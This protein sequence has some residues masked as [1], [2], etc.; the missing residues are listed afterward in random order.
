[1]FYS[2][3]RKWLRP[4][5]RYLIGRYQ[6]AAEHPTG[7]KIVHKT[8]SRQHLEVAVGLVRGEDSSQGQT[9][10]QI[11]IRCLK[12]KFGTTVNG[13]A[14]PEGDHD[15]VG[16]EHEIALGKA[17]YHLKIVWQPVALSFSFGSKEFK[18]GKDPLKEVRKRLDNTDIV[19]ALEYLK[20]QTTHVVAGKRN[21]AKGLQALVNGRYMVH[22]TFVDALVYCT[23]PEN[24]D[25]PESFCPLE[26]DFDQQ[27][28]DAL[29]YLPPRSKEPNERPSEDFAPNIHRA[30][31]FEGYTFV[32][33]D[34]VQFD[35]L[36]APISDGG[37]KTLHFAVEP[38]VTEA[39]DLLRYVKSA[40]GEKGLGE[41]EDGSEG[42]GVVIVKLIA[43]KQ[44]QWAEQFVKTVS[45][46]T[47][48]RMIEQNEFLEAILS[49]N[50]GIL[51]RPLSVED[52]PGSRDAPQS[53]TQPSP[54]EETQT[55]IKMDS[56]PANLRERRARRAAAKKF[57]GF[58]DEVEDAPVSIP[59]ASG[60]DMQSQAP[61]SGPLAP[62]K[63]GFHDDMDDEDTTKP[64]TDETQLSPAG[65]SKKRPAPEEE[66]DDMIDAILPAAAAL[67]RRRIEERE[68]GNERD[69]SPVSALST[70]PTSKAKRP[71]KEIDIKDVVRKRREAEEEA[72]RRDEESLQDIMQ[73]M[74]VEQMKSL[75]VVEEME[76]PSRSRQHPRRS[77]TGEHSDRWD[78]RWNGRKNFKKFRRQGDRNQA[79]RGQAVIVP[80]E[81][82]KKKG[83]GIGEDYWLDTTSTSRKKRK[84]AERTGQ[85]ESR[86]L[87]SSKS[88][89]PAE[90]IQDV[91]PEP[92]IEGENS[93]IINI[94]APRQT[95]HSDHSGPNNLDPYSQ[96]GTGPS[97][98]TTSAGVQPSAVS[99]KRPRRAIQE[100]SESDSEDDMKFRFKRR[101]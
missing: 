44:P 58:D 8:V 70:Q 29:Q 100:Q 91:L 81:E 62:R 74:N 75:A 53:L 83:Y 94:D 71:K 86:P 92:V 13:D 51:R 67:K 45:L 19:C 5:K 6:A 12:T 33:C 43:D 1:M 80:L 87:S 68:N 24:L 34:Q 96:S 20:G 25:E 60:Q 57:K 63:Y 26:L 15:L 59:Q 18:R 17:P 28:P 48:Q 30:I 85:A 11:T 93:E 76:V 56:S 79:R 78:D 46:A 42:K 77:A 66:D 88:Q 14:V 89:Q 47:G 72:A 37:G 27:W 21:T 90:Q 54:P 3:K 99:A 65:Q 35:T 97:V 40:A 2:D 98:S 16:D 41:F 39:A 31:I 23:T 82:V 4:G 52:E 7:L 55:S 64:I 38:G 32:F 61:P 49:N 73:G 9:R 10:S 95:R 69:P 84:D 22:S 36:H 101:R 50:A